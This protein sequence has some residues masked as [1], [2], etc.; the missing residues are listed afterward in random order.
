MNTLTRLLP[1][2]GALVAF[3]M[4]LSPNP[5]EADSLLV[6][7]RAD[8]TAATFSGPDEVNPFLPGNALHAFAQVQPDVLGVDGQFYLQNWDGADGVFTTTSISGPGSPGAQ[9]FLHSPLIERIEAQTWRIEGPSDHGTLDGA[10]NAVV[11]R[12]KVLL[13][14]RVTFGAASLTIQGGVPVGLSYAIDFSQP[15]VPADFGNSALASVEFSAITVTSSGASFGAAQTFTIGVD[16][17]GVPHG[18]NTQLL[19]G[20]YPP[21]LLSSTV[22]DTTRGLLRSEIL[23]NSDEIGGA[24]A[25]ISADGRLN[26]APFPSSDTPSGQVYLANPFAGA[27]GVLTVYSATGFTAGV[28]LIPEPSALPLAGL[29]WV[30]ATRRRRGAR[31]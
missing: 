13:P 27:S 31:G 7:F 8:L 24:T 1:F 22:I 17:A 6:S 9:F 15:G 29:A 26:G 10:G 19:L 16:D 11:Q 21:S 3:A 23:N 2:A 5:A 4:A 20:S 25:N 28:A 30:A 14:A 12:D 18:L